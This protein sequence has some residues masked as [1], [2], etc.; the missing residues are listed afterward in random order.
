MVVSS[1]SPSLLIPSLQLHLKTCLI[2]TSKGAWSWTPGESPNSCHCGLQV[3]PQTPI[4][5][6]LKLTWSWPPSIYANFC[7]EGLQVYSSMVSTRVYTTAQLQCPVQYWAHSA[8]ASNCICISN[9]WISP[10]PTWKPPWQ[11]AQPH[12][13]FDVHP[14]SSRHPWH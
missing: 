13:C 5:V 9:M 3:H 7:Q 2:I 6:A 10:E 14:D 1:E 11:I 4:Y 12:M 8:F